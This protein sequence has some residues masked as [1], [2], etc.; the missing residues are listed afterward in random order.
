MSTFDFKQSE[1]SYTLYELNQQKLLTS[2]LW[3][4]EYMRMRKAANARISRL[5]SAGFEGTRTYIKNKGR[6][7]K[8]SEITD[9][10]DMAYYLSE[11]H[12]FLESPYTTVAGQRKIQ[13]KIL[14][15]LHE[16]HYDFVTAENLS[17]FGDFM[18]FALSSRY[19]RIIP[20]DEIADFWN[21][22]KEDDA[23]ISSTELEGAFK[24]WGKEREKALRK[25]QESRT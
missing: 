4:E 15:R 22:R 12:D 1:D 5:E 13:S 16:H 21:D 3:R 11:L 19:S 17:E 24:E 20:S 7:P 8:L 18:N 9:E 25:Y 6:Y 14:E 10:R 2:E 23:D